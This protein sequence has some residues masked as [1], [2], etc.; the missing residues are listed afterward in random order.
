MRKLAG[1]V[2]L[3]LAVRLATAVASGTVFLHIRPD[4]IVITLVVLGLVLLLPP[5]KPTKN[6]NDHTRTESR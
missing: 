2:S 5:Q 3:V 1:L 4:L 6:S